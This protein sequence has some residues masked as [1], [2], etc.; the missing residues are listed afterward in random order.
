MTGEAPGDFTEQSRAI[1]EMVDQIH[2]R[3]SDPNIIV[4]VIP[5]II[6]SYPVGEATVEG[7]LAG[8]DVI[9]GLTGTERFIPVIEEMLKI[10]TGQEQGETNE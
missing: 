1:D 5:E 6:A 9:P 3:N 2:V 10:D 4:S 8:L 7:V